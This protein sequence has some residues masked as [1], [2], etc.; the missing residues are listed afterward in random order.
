M[1]ASFPLLKTTLSTVLILVLGACGPEGVGGIELLEDGDIHERVKYVVNGQPYSGHP[2][3]GKLTHSGSLC[4]ATL[5]GKKTV[6]TAAHC[7][8]VGYSHTFTVGGQAYTSAKVVRHPQYS[9]YGYSNDIAIIILQTAPTVQG[10]KIATSKPPVGTEITIVGYGKTSEYISNAGI[11]RMAKTNIAEV[12]TTRVRIPGST[13]KAG[14]CNGDSGGPSYATLNGV[15]VQIGVHS[16]KSG[17]CGTGGHDT[18]V[19][20]FAAWITTTAAGDVNKPGSG[21]GGGGGD[22]NPPVDAEAPKVNITYPQAGA[23]VNKNLTITTK[24]SD[25]KAVTKM[26]LFVDGKVVSSGSA[27]NFPV[28][29]QPGTHNLRVVASDAASNKG[30]ASVTVIVP[31]ATN[32]NPKPDP[33]PDPKP[34]PNKPDPQPQ[35]DPTPTPTPGTFGAT[36]QNPN[37]CLSTM[38]ADDQTLGAQYCTQG[39]GATLAC[40]AGSTCFTT[41]GQG[42][43]GLDTA[44][45]SENGLTDSELLGSCSV[46]QG[47]DRASA[48]WLVLVG[49]A[50]LGLVLFRRRR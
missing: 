49:L 11:K 32:P 10:A 30:Q 35:P 13:T 29:L 28:A 48:S 46:A 17:T 25:N 23:T 14:I 34:D 45:P 20:A 50:L 42:I 40:P 38:C 31:G 15:E 41:S 1:R 6:V 8:S 44:P 27:Q 43:C 7:V 9:S 26:E 36:C 21:G 19:D 5:I 2:S 4:T 37:E 16:T 18:R 39:C 3:A 24:I 12:T 33:P 47:T 22:T